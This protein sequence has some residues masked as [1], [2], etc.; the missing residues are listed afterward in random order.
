MVTALDGMWHP[1]CFTCVN[2]DSILKGHEYV[3]EQGKQ[4]CHPCHAKLFGPPCCV[5]HK[6]TGEVSDLSID[7]LI[8]KSIN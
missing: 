1:E 2:C 3:V 4:Y 7:Q 6:P 5:C 8:K